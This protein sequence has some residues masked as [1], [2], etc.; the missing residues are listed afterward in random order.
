M[1]H[2]RLSHL[3]ARLESGS[4]TETD[5]DELESLL[6][7]D[8]EARECF[9]D[10]S[11]MEGLLYGVDRESTGTKVVEFDAS[12]APVGDEPRPGPRP[13]WVAAPAAAIALLGTVVLWPRPGDVAEPLVSGGAESAEPTP[14]APPALSAEERYDRSRLADTGGASRAHP[15]AADNAELVPHS[16]RVEFNRDIRPILSDQC[17]T[18]HGPDEAERKADLRLDTEEGATGDLG[19]YAAV[20]KG[21]PDASELVA[22]VLEDDPDSVMP[23]PESS[24]TLTDEQKELLR[25]WVEEG[26]EWQQHW[27]FESPMARSLPEVSD[28]A[29]PA[30][31]IDFFILDQL[32]GRGLKP[33]PDAEPATLIRRLSL[34]LT[35]LPP[36][37]EQVDAFVADPSPEA[38]G[39]L[40]DRLLDS[41]A[42]AEHMAWQWMDAARYA[43]TDGYQN[44][45]PRDMWRWR[46]W[47]IE[48]YRSNMPFD[49]FTVAQLA[50]D[51]LPDPTRDQLVATG[52]NRNH[53][54]N[55]EAGLV[56]EEFLLENAADRVDTTMT[57][58]MGLTIACA[59][60]HD[61]KYDPLTQ[62][63]YYRLISFFDNIS[64]S[65][66]AVKVGNS[67]PWIKA[68][69]REQE[70]ELAEI[71]YRLSEATKQLEQAE[72]RLRERQTAWEKSDP[73][74]SETIVAD[75]LSHRYGI[76]RTVEADGE[77]PVNLKD[78]VNGLVSNN[79]FSIAFDL[80]PETVDRG[81]V[82]SNEAADTKRQGM[83]V[84]FREGHLQFAIVSRW[85]AG[86]GMLETLES[87]EPGEKIHVA[88]TND[89]TQRAKGMAIWIDGEKVETRVLHNTNSNAVGVAGK[90]PMLAGGSKHMPSWKGSLSD[91]RFYSERTLSPWDIALLANPHE[92]PAILAKPSEVRSATEAEKLRHYF[93]AHGAE[94]ADR[95]LAERVARIEGE[96][97]R[98]ADALPTTMVMEES[99]TPKQTHLRVRGEYHNKGEVVESGVPEVFGSM[100]DDL[101]ADRLG[102][103]R[104]LTSDDNPLAGRVAANRYWQML[105]GAGL[106]KT[107]EDFGTQGNSPSHPELLDWLALEFQESGWNTRRMLKLMVT[108]RTYRQSSGV[109]EEL[110]QKDPGNV[111]LARAP[112]LKL[113]GN[114]LRDQALVAGGLLVPDVGGPSV[115]PYQ[116]ANLWKEASNFSYKQDSGEALYRRSLYTYWKRTLAPPS[117]AV[118][119]T[120]DRE[121][122]SV[123]PKRT[124]TPLQA[125]TLLNETAFFEA[126]RKLGE[127]M[128]TLPET[129]V[130]ARLSYG[131]RSV[132]SR[133]P[134]DEELKILTTAYQ[135]YRDGFAADPEGAKA[136]QN[137][138]ESKPD[139]SIDPVELAAAAAVANVIINLEEASVRE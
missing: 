104:W 39:K 56:L 122:C 94:P 76:D 95:Q 110:L 82:L 42:H 49:R 124:N 22:R 50:G 47:V 44:D 12:V 89:G 98:F 4:A 36:T 100:D 58:W 102:L 67:E 7:D 99:P 125:L 109:R 61:H 28:P 101:P 43:D 21:D 57:V 80:V 10:H 24:R 134:R 25:R 135:R 139:P 127:R 14:A 83:F 37:V 35:G 32:D 77:K 86:V 2:E 51:L 26:A 96:R 29:W 113:P 66:R 62:R 31:P 13:G 133:E 69:T 52:F 97:T 74:L 119:D 112:R 85:V 138:G 73:N 105:F 130:G 3:L 8:Y 137:V 63:D 84:A 106:V 128:W 116:P 132:L 91:L 18:C 129:E 115:K 114:A 46:D 64:E 131:F 55:S 16:S 103:A 126:A 93:L 11:Q 70:A 9:V 120:A 72:P 111:F 45:G 81:V 68:P 54:Y 17:F 59:R 123:K 40:V 118:L 117:M 34:D 107:T 92:L 19:G 136:L 121:W 38:Y 33:S 87:F 60:C 20:V 53:R 71:D 30:N 90:T 15:G 6:A 88:L 48:A 5:L 41:D 108:S 1:E 78:K 75:G 27:A 65:G 79:R 23:P